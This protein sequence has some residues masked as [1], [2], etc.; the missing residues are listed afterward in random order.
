MNKKMK[1]IKGVK[2]KF[3]Y[4]VGSCH[5]SIARYVAPSLSLNNPM[6]VDKISTKD[7]WTGFNIIIKNHCYDNYN[8]ENL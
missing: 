6:L 2:K 4:I 1:N 3:I 7:G 8:L 5:A